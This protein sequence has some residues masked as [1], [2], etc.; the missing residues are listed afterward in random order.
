[1]KSLK[2]KSIS[3]VSHRE[4][5]AFKHSFHP[6]TNLVK[7]Q[8]DTG[9][10]TLLKSIFYAL[11]AE[12]H[13]RTERWRSADALA[14]VEFEIGSDDYSI[15]RYRN[16]FSLFDGSGEH[17]SSY[18]SVTKELAPKLAKLFSFKLKLQNQQGEPETPTPAF[19]Y[20]PYY[21]DQDKG[22]QEPWSSFERLGQYSNW[23]NLVTSYHFGERPDE[24]YELDASKRQAAADLEEPKRQVATLDRLLTRSEAEI[25]RVDFDVDIEAFKKELE[26][27]LLRCN[28]LQEKED[29]YKN[30]LIELNTERIRLAAQIEIVAKTHNELNADYKFAA[31]HLD[32]VVD[33]PI[34]GQQYDNSFRER[35]E[36]AQDSETCLDLLGSL[37]IDLDETLRKID[38]LRESLLIT[39]QQKAEL[40]ELLA[41]RRGEVRLD[42]LV[43]AEGKKQIIGHLV[44]E[45]DQENAKIQEIERTIAEI[46]QEKAR[47]DSRER[48]QAIRSAYHDNMRRYAFKLNLQTMNE[49]VFQNIN[50]RINES[51]SDQPRAVLAYQ[52][53]VLDAIRAKKNVT[54]FPL[55]IDAPNQQEQDKEN[56]KKILR[57]IKEHVQSDQQLI[58]GLVDDFG[59]RF[60]GDQLVLERK[61]FLLDENQYEKIANELQ[62]FEAAHLDLKRSQ[63]GR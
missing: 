31:E 9:K 2:L 61:H 53:A 1:M 36:I 41:S 17:I 50:G 57:F 11:G 3:L 58:L 32:D 14:L 30:Q 38:A 46:E 59:V 54:V 49:K 25:A 33:C 39:Q 15:L 12:P 13:G 47:F 22:W 29:A 8:N 52:F 6:G 37:K 10:S 24:W 43:R 7:G 48:K 56:I 23:K 51:G 27:L 18:N 44:S 19:M 20:L 26:R 34:C 63:R 60:D 35:F 42:D 28:N 62:P 21:I 45:I 40:E 4:R 16:A 5:K 55:V